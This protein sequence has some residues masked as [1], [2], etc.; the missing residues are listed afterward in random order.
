M[1]NTLRPTPRTDDPDTGEFFEA[2]A[3]HEVAVCACDDCGRVLHLPKAF[4]HGCG[5]WNTGW[6]TVAPTATLW[7]WTTTERQLN[8][9]FEAPWTVVTVE[10]DEVPGA[11][12]LGHLPG[13]PDLEIGMPMRA[14]FEDLDEGTT[15]VQWQPAT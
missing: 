11:R 10:L 6:R 9:V 5:S 8:P 4:C 13:R 3:R 15:L 12:L 2:A 1:S 7:S 14:V